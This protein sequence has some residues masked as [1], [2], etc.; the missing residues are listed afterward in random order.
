MIDQLA[1]RLRA[2]L[3]EHRPRAG[4]LWATLQRQHQTQPDEVGGVQQRLGDLHRHA[5][6][7]VGRVALVRELPCRQPTGEAAFD[8]RGDQVVLVR[9][10]PVRSSSQAIRTSY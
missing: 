5:L 3:Q 10:M 8:H 7:A 9:E 4:F 2:G 6:H 1:V